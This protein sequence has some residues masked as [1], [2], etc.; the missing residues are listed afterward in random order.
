MLAEDIAPNRMEKSKQLV[1]QIIN[2]LGSDRVG[3]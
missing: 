2:N 3:L 1:T